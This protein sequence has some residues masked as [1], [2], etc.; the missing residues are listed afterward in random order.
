MD[1]QDALES[2]AAL[3]QETRLAA[4]RLLVR[5]EPEGLAAGEIARRLAVPHNTLSAHLGVLSRARWVV[6]FR[7]G[8]SIVYR[9]NLAR[10]REVILFLAADC[11]AAHPQA[12]TPLLAGLDEEVKE[13]GPS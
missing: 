9:A 6:S 4:F 10:A 5:E 7:R 13:H 2:F 11:C 1:T 12:C 3:A 8:R